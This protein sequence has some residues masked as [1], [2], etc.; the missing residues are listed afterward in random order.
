LTTPLIILRVFE[1]VACV[2]GFIHWEKIRTSVFRWFPVYLCFIVISEFIGQMLN[3]PA[4]K[5]ANI[6]FFNYFEIPVEFLFFFWLFFKTGKHHK[7]QNLPVFYAGIYLVAWLIDSLYLNRLQFSFYSFSYTIGNLL[8]LLL[9]L[10]YFIQLVTSNSIL[11]F[12][13]D[14]MFWIC[15]GLLFYYLGTFPFYGLRNTLGT[16]YPQLYSTYSYI[17]YAL[18]SLMYLMFTFSFIWGRPNLKYL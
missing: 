15:T 5:Q 7:Y 12:A 2:T 10:R 1:L 18:N 4:M 13:N 11:G 3:E 17:M 9:I 8:L 6:A 14:I 16:N